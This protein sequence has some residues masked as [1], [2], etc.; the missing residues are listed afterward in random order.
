VPRR[1]LPPPLPPET[2]TVGQLVAES[3]RLYGARFWPSLALG[4][5]PAVVGAG[6]VE[7]PRTLAWLLVPTVGTALWSAAYI[8]AC[9]LALRT[10]SANTGVAF[11]AGCVAF[12]PLLVQRMAVVPGFDLVTLAYFAFVSL[13][14]PAALAERLSFAAALRRGTRLARADYVHALG[15]LAT[16]VITIFLSGLVLVVVLHGFSDQAIR[17]AA[18]ISLLVLA[19]VF[20]LGAALLYVD[21]SAR[22]VSSASRPRRPGDADVHPALEPDGAGRADAEV[23]PGPAARGES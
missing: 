1:E 9:R 11:L 12:A 22:V 6:L 3:V 15:S 2:R 18:L 20:L 4:I 8:G 23:E 19:P 16:L 10:G 7:L 14:V 13:A 5:G 21:Q 17:A